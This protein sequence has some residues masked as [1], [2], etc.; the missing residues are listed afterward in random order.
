MYSR[1]IDVNKKF[2][3]SVNLEYDLKNEEKIKEYIP[4]SDLC[5]VLEYYISSALNNKNLR[6]TLLVGPYGKGKSYLMLMITYLLGKRENKALFN[7]VVDKIKKI[8]S[9]LAN[10][11]IKI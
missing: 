8:N 1:Y 9:N 4:T 10:M 3:S 7:I 2:K 11:L 5:D 6:S